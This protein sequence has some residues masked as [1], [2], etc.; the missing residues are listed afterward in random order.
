MRPQASGSLV[1]GSN[2]C[3][4]PEVV[5]VLLISLLCIL[6]LRCAGH[7]G[8]RNLLCVRPHS[9]FTKIWGGRPFC[10]PPSTSE[11]DRREE[12]PSPCWFTRLPGRAEPTPREHSSA[13]F[14]SS[15]EAGALRL[16]QLPL[17]SR[18]GLGPDKSWLWELTCALQ[19][20][21]CTLWLVPLDAS[22]TPPLPHTLPHLPRGDHPNC[23]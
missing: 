4:G 23:R 9:V 8:T 22:N 15:P 11:E 17:E 20:V 2:G 1:H 6:C 12:S 10:C 7:W 19:D 16:P 18:E 13:S 3:H 21:D 14:T 5:S